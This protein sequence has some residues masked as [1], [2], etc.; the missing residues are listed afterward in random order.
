M[1]R[2]LFLCPVY[3]DWW[4]RG[5]SNS[6]PSACKAAALPTELQ[7]HIWQGTW[8]FNPHLRSAKR[9]A[10]R[11]RLTC[12]NATLNFQLYP[13]LRQLPFPNYAF[14]RYRLYAAQN[15]ITDTLLTVLNTAVLLR[16]LHKARVGYSV[17]HLFPIINLH[18]YYISFSVH[19][20]LLLYM[21]LRY[22][23][24]EF[25]YISTSRHKER[26]FSL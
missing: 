26:R 5:D 10:N 4:R 17:S 14:G 9:R 13:V 3:Q 12:S 16:S 8:D 11:N 1:L 6:R 21:N 24:S 7:P 18:I 22:F 15:G 2:V 19:C 20:Q 25:L 23:Y